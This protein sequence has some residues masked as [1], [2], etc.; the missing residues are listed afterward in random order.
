LQP[1]REAQYGSPNVPPLGF[2][3]HE[4]TAFPF[5]SPPSAASIAP[6]ALIP[7]DVPWQVPAYLQL[8]GM[9]TWGHAVGGIEGTYGLD[10]QVHV[11]ILK[12]TFRTRFRPFSQLWASC[13]IP[14]SIMVCGNH[15]EILT[16]CPTLGIG[17][18]ITAILA[19]SG[20]N[21][22]HL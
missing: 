1:L 18:T 2:H 8:G 5:I 16:G 11:A 13:V 3:I 22:S 9:D 6:I 14:G 19:E 7:V 20:Q 15:R 17:G 10:P 21:R 12:P 4:R